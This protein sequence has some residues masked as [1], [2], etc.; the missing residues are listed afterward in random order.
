MQANEIQEALGPKQQ[1]GGVTGICTAGPRAC[2]PDFI[3]TMVGEGE[4]FRGPQAV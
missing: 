2:V 3:P 4:S 1:Q